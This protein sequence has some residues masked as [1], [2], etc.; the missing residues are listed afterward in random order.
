[1]L[2]KHYASKFTRIIAKYRY[3]LQCRSCGAVKNRICDQ[4]ITA[5]S[6]YVILLAISLSQWMTW[7][8]PRQVVHTCPSPNS[9]QVYE[10][11]GDMSFAVADPWVCSMLFHCIWRIIIHVLDICWRHRRLTEA[12]AG[13]DIFVSGTIYKFSYQH[14]YLW[15]H[16]FT[17]TV[18]SLVLAIAA[19]RFCPSAFSRC[20]DCIW[21]SQ[22]T[23]L[24]LIFRRTSV[25][26][27][28]SG[29]QAAATVI[30]VM[31]TL[32]IITLCLT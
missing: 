13:S 15:H 3:N 8:T 27:C 16:M 25:C 32:T 5:Y 17:Y 28:G 22:S 12:V 9:I 18:L 6:T 2:S 4:Q 7:L 29:L 20:Q 1:M 24:S 14:T 19:I 10:R 23:Q 21:S 11:L 30:M 26:L 31:A